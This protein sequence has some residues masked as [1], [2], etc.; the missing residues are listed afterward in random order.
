MPAD[1]AADGSVVR[2]TAL[3]VLPL[4]LALT[5]CTSSEQDDATRAADGFV[6]A[7]S[8]GRADRA[9]DLLAPVT[10]QELEQSAGAPCV[11]AVLEEATGG[12]RRLEVST[13]GDM[14]QVRYAEDVLFLSRYAGGWRVVAAG[15]VAQLGAP[16]SCGIE[17]R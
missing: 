17:G 1:E 6:A 14:A 3:L 13:F 5:S 4:A 10:R 9:C 7:V 16:Y 8:D 15:C 2:M 11:D 12:G